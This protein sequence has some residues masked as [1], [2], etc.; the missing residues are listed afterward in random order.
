MDVVGAR[1]SYN[2]PAST[3][4]SRAFV[5]KWLAASAVELW[6]TRMGMLCLGSGNSQSHAL[7]TRAR[8]CSCGWHGNA[9]AAVLLRR[10]DRSRCS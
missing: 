1:Q 5:A 10:S 6:A 7:T 2:E 4:I 9:T 3:Y 8:R